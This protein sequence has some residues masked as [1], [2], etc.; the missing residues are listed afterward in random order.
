MAND[1]QFHWMNIHQSKI[2]D[3][4]H[5]SNLPIIFYGD[6]NARNPYWNDTITNR[7]GYKFKEVITDLES[8]KNL[9]QSSIMC[10]NSHDFHYRKKNKPSP[11][12]R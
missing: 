7:N 1:I 10:R 12:N 5:Y 9:I 11:P 6:F 2:D 4:H 8:Q 3:I